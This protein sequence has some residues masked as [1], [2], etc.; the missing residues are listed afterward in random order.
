MECLLSIR[1]VAKLLGSSPSHVR[2]LISAEE[3]PEP[4]RPGGRMIRWSPEVIQR[5]I[6]AGCPDC[7]DSKGGNA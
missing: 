6:D 4:L 2:R 3:I 5:W 7:R 1:D